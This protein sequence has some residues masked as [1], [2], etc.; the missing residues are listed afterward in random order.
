MREYSLHNISSIPNFSCGVYAIRN[1]MDNKMYIG[2][3]TNIR[4][5]IKYHINALKNNKD[6]N[7]YL[8]EVVNDIGL[9]K[10]SFIILE[11]CD[12]NRNTLKYLENKYIEL[13][14]Y[15]NK[16]KVD[17]KPVFCYSLNGQYI[18]VFTNLKEAAKFVNGFPDNIKACCE[19]R[20]NKKSYHGFQWSYIKKC[21]IGERTR[22]DVYHNCKSIQQFSASGTLLNTYRSIGQASKMT[23][24]AKSAIQS[25]LN[26]K[27]IN[28]TDGGYIWKYKEGGNNE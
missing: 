23:N 7:R 12:D 2:S 17:G 8:Q 26:I 4:S 11:M 10:F 27:K 5:K 19:C 15:Y 24:I 21:N 13:Y 3:S 9:D 20:K 6:C 18:C 16:N 1:N 25:V 14:G 28:K 22:K